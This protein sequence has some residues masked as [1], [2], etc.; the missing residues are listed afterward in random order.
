MVSIVTSRY[1]GGLKIV[2]ISSKWQWF[3]SQE[4][5]SFSFFFLNKYLFGS[6]CW[7]MPGA[8]SQVLPEVSS[9]CIGRRKRRPKPLWEPRVEPTFPMKPRKVLTYNLQDNISCTC[10]FAG[11]LHTFLHAFKYFAFRNK[12]FLNLLRPSFIFRD[13]SF[14][15]FFLFLQQNCLKSN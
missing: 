7:H 9:R 4:L 15:C 2:S 13:L 14:L 8:R 12:V 11:N 5:V 6:T 10:S 3:V 1:G